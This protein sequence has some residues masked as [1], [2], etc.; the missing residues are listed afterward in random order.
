MH[1][2]RETAYGTVGITVLPDGDEF[3]AVVVDAPEVLRHGCP[4]VATGYTPED[5]LGVLGV[6]IDRY[7]RLHQD[8]QRQALERQKPPVE[9]P[10]ERRRRSTSASEAPTEPTPDAVPS[11]AGSRGGR[12]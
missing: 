10:V 5:A 8:L 3:W 11:A 4:T 6:S 2:Q 12:P 7:I 9:V 1:V